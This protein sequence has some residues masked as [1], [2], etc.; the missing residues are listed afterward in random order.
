MIMWPIVIGVSV[1]D[2]RQTAEEIFAAKDRACNHSLASI[3]ERETVTEQIFALSSDFEAQDDFPV[4]IP[5]WY[6][7][8]DR[9]THWLLV[10][11]QAHIALGKH[12]RASIVPI[13]NS[14]AGSWKTK[15]ALSTLEF[16]IFADDDAILYTGA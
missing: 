11:R 13:W 15:V 3:P 12:H 10:W 9:S 7:V 2:D 5:T 1:D 16:L 14:K 8:P 6:L 4:A